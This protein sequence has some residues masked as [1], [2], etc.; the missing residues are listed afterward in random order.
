MVNSN[1]SQRKP[2][3]GEQLSRR[4]YDIIKLTLCNDYDGVEE[5][6]EKDPDCINDL[7]PEFGSSALHIAAADGL[8]GI[9]KLLLAS[10]SVDLT[11]RDRYNRL[12][13]D[14]ALDA[15]HHDIMNEIIDA[16]HSDSPDFE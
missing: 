16:M 7:H 11:I 14:V 5:A 1:N 10:P 2:K 8:R 6:L 12:A 3:S 4:F 9:T 13:R 15:G